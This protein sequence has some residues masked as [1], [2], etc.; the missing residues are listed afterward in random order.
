MPVTILSPM[1]FHTIGHSDLN[2]LDLIQERLSFPMI[3]K[4]AF[5]SFGEQVY[6]ARSRKQLEQIIKQASSTEL[7]FQQ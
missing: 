2:F 5:G 1:T 3:V 6:L 4:E 7:I